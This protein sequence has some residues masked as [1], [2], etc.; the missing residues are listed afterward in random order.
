MAKVYV[1]FE[2]FMAVVDELM[3]FCWVSAY[4]VDEC[5]DVPEEV[6]LSSETW[7]SSPATL[8]RNPA[9]DNELTNVSFTDAA[10]D[11]SS[12]CSAYNYEDCS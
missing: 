5:F 6:V 10:A 11:N 1:R 12:W 7:E 3:A 8:R 2:A 9:E 4:V